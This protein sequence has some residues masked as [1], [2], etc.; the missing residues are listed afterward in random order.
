MLARIKSLQNGP[1]LDGLIKANLKEEPSKMTGLWKTDD[2]EDTVEN[3][4]GFLCAVAAKGARLSKSFLLERLK[5]VFKTDHV[6]LEDFA[7]K[8]SQALRYCHG[9]SKRLTSGKKTSSATL[10]VITAYGMK[11]PTTPPSKGSSSGSLELPCLTDGAAGGDA[12]CMP[13]DSQ[14]EEEDLSVLFGSDP[15]DDEAMLALQKAKDMYKDC[16]GSGAA[17][18]SDVIEVGDSP[19]KSPPVPHN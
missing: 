6:T 9:K 1:V 18:S 15:E 19:M 8:M 13:V 17:S 11:K 16:R 2:I 12:D 4:N 5:K 7:G 14:T 10:K 3:F